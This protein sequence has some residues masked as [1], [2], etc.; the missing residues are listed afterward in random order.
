MR[1]P[2]AERPASDRQMEVL[3]AVA[4]YVLEERMPPTLRELAAVLGV[5]ATNGVHEILD[6]LVTKGL[7]GRKPLKS[8]GIWVTDAGL[9]ELQRQ[10]LSH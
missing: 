2:K 9:V 8:R 10:G 1:T 3:V 5:T 4:R 6:Q 7:L